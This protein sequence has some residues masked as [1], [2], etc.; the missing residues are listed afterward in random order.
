M[1]P[2]A[3]TLVLIKRELLVAGRMRGVW[4]EPIAF[5]SLILLIFP[6]VTVVERAVLEQIAPGVLW[7][8]ALL[9]GA[10]SVGRLVASDH[11]DGS[12]DQ[13][14][15]SPQSLPAVMLTKSLVH[16][17]TTGVP[18]SLLAPLYGYL[19]L[20]SDAGVWITVVSLFLGTWL[21][22][23]IGLFGA[24]LTINLRRGHLL[25]TVLSLPFYIPGMIFGSTAMVM[26]GEGFDATGALALLI[27]LTVM[28]TVLLPYAAAVAIRTMTD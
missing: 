17:L 3:H 20:L 25:L 10:L 24:A 7:V 9:A 6:L 5:F 19:W 14:L 8:A 28:A 12:L 2:K 16:W 21:V 1:W 27:A 4:L 26:A 18:L 23:L 13:L 15:C 22:S 11:A